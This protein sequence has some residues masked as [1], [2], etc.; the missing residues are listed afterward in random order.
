MTVDDIT[1]QELIDEL[2][3]LGL[4]MTMLSSG[5]SLLYASFFPANKVK[6]RLGQK[7]TELAETISKKL[8]PAHQKHIIFEV[9][10]ED[11]TGEDVEVPYIMISRK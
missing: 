9:V 8:I 5:V 10:V 4:T 1:C 3:K 7:L 11:A 6:P 2:E